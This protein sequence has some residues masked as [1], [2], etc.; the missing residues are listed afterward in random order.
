MFKETDNKNYELTI[1]KQ[2][3]LS[4]VVAF[5]L[6]G[7]IIGIAAAVVEIVGISIGVNVAIIMHWISFGLM[8]LAVI[9]ILIGIILGITSIKTL[10]KK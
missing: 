10:G 5:L 9:N 6:M 2:R 8:I 3:A 1:K 4:S 7:C